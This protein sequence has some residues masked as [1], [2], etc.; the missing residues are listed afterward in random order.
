MAEA[1]IPV[2]LLNPGQVFACLGF[3]EAADVLCGGAEGGF[4]WSDKMA[5]RFTLRAA[6]SNNPVATVLAFLA[7]ATVCSVVPIHSKLTTMKPWSVPTRKVGDGVFP[8]PEPDAPAVLPAVLA[9]AQGRQIEIEHWGDATRRDAVKFW[10]GAG[11][12]PGVALARDALD[13]VRSSALG[14][15]GDPFALSAPQTSSFRLDWRRDYIPVELGFSPNEHGALTMMGFPLVELL[16]VIGLQN[17]R[18]ERRDRLTYRYG[19]P[20]ICLPPLFFRAQLGCAPLPF[21]S[22]TFRMCLG[23]PGQEGQARCIT[24]VTEDIMP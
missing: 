18:P 7:S 10:A 19:T 8:F 5:T 6:G 24:D 22:R 17:A 20:G 13:L 2:D 3:V 9:D 1:Q 4:D 23:W 21:P 16:A 15:V 11:G 12:Y 14:A